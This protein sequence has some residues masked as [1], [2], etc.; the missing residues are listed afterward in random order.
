M[1]IIAAFAIT[2]GVVFFGVSLLLGMPARDGFLFAVG[3][4]VALVPEGL[5]PTLTLALAMSASRMASRGALVRHLEAVET[6]GSTTVICSDKTGTITANQMTRERCWRRS[7][8]L[9]VTGT[10]YDP[11]GAVLLRADHSGQRR[12]TSL[13]PL[14]RAAALCNDSRRLAR[15]IGG[16]WW[17]TPRKE[18]LIVL[19][20][21]AASIESGR[22][23][24]SAAGGGVPVRLRS[25]CG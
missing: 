23:A 18:R 17:E 1:K 24:R 2:A 10:G 9:D 21:K 11:S 16:P 22:S 20:R 6:L 15:R 3:V 25:S 4:I 12:S 13:E 14:F 19:A 7:A 8:Q 5:L